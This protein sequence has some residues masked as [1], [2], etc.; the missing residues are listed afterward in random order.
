MPPSSYWGSVDGAPAAKH[1]SVHDSL[2]LDSSLL[3]VL[4]ADSRRDILRLLK[5][6][7]MTLT[8]MSTQ[9]GLKKAT[10]LEHLKKLTDS[11]LIKRMEDERL[12]VYYELTRQGSRIVNPGRTRFYLIMSAT[13]VAG[14]LLGGVL[15]VALVHNAPHVIQAPTPSGSTSAQGTAEHDVAN[16]AGS[17]DV[18]GP[19]AAPAALPGV[20]LTGPA[21]AWRGLDSNVT[22]G[23]QRDG[24]ALDGAL[25][26]ATPDSRGSLTL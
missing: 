9:M 19:T 1:P 4:A 13:A 5:Q 8:E 22:L 15:A 12:W 11:G 18:R 26:L 10:V 16:N 7:R 3:K 2:P 6:R 21:T 24:V 17:S 14:L 25:L 20:T 23:V